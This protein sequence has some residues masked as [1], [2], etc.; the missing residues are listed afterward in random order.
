[1]DRPLIRLPDGLY[2]V[3]HGSVCAGFVIEDG[4]VVRCAPILRKRMDFWV[5]RSRRCAELRVV[6]DNEMTRGFKDEH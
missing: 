3:E 2:R 6:T 5:R 1:M 4:R